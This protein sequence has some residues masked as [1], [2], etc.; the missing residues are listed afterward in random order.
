MPGGSR[1]Y[2]A[3]VRQIAK[4]AVEGDL[5][6]RPSGERRAAQQFHR[7]GRAPLDDEAHGAGIAL[8]E[9]ALQQSQRHAEQAGQRRRIELDVREVALDE[10]AGLSEALLRQAVFCELW[11]CVPSPA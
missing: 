3:E 1:E 10:P 4:P 7:A 6:D 8:G 9:Y 5:G 11:I 2:T